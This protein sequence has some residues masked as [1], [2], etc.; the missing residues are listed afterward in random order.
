LLT[1]SWSSWSVRKF[2]LGTA[3]GNRAK[4]VEQFRNRRLGSG[5]RSWCTH[6]KRH[7]EAVRDMD[8]ASAA[9]VESQ[10]V[11]GW[12]SWRVSTMCSKAQSAS[13]LK[14]R[15]AFCKQSTKTGWTRLQSNTQGLAKAKAV[16]ATSRIENQVESMYERAD[17]RFR[18]R[19]YREGLGSWKVAATDARRRKFSKQKAISSFAQRKRVQICRVWNIYSHN[20]IRHKETLQK[21]GS[22]MRSCERAKTLAVL[23]CDAERRN[24]RIGMDKKAWTRVRVVR[25]QHGIKL[26][27]T[28]VTTAKFQYDV[29]QRG[30]THFRKMRFQVLWDCLQEM[31]RFQEALLTGSKRFTAAHPVNRPTIVSFWWWQ[32]VAGWMKEASQRARL[33]NKWMSQRAQAQ[34]FYQWSERLR[35]SSGHSEGPAQE[36]EAPA[37]E[38]EAPT[39]ES[40]APAG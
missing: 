39:G 10:N 21:A 23:R 11:A 5:L 22:H 2:Q 12:S 32:D 30:D 24:V 13:M 7:L 20:C 3:K 33:A 15:V 28:A 40:D 1:L 35:C 4:G 29:L 19:G 6:T 31:E 8:K 16:R 25:L 14:G 38:L 26:W 18:S 17:K 27:L 34:S 36:P 9:F 37:E